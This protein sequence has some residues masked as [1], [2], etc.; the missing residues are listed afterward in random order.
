V[1]LDATRKVKIADFG[2]ARHNHMKVERGIGT[3]AYMPPEMLV[4]GDEETNPLAVDVYAMGVIMW[5]LWFREV[6][7]EGKAVHKIMSMVTRG[8]RPPMDKGDDLP[9]PELAALINMCWVQEHENRL[10]IDQVFSTFDEDIK[11]IIE[12]NFT[13]EE[14]PE[15]RLSSPLDSNQTTQLT[16]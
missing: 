8:K 11:P 12:A 14:A 6:P 9:P 2:L 16:F 13:H 4:E 7:F 5:Q 10:T 1:L 15:S 3:P